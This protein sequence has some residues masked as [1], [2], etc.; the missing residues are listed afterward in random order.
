M[1]L[2][3]AEDERV[4]GNYRMVALGSCDKSDDKGVDR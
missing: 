4:A 3:K 1:P 2:F